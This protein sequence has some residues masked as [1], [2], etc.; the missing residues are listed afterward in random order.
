M[1]RQSLIDLI[2]KQ[3]AREV[4]DDFKCYHNALGGCAY[5]LPKTKQSKLKKKPL[6]YKV[7]RAEADLSSECI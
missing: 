5:I 6:F 4:V 1:K 7:G 3:F 2:N